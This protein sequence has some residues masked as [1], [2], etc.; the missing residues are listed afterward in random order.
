MLGLGSRKRSWKWEAKPIRKGAA[1][2]ATEQVWGSI[3]SAPLILRCLACSK[4]QSKGA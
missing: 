2:K 1:E 3:L 4:E